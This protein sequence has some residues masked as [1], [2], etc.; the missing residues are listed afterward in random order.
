MPAEVVEPPVVVAPEPKVPAEPM[1]IGDRYGAALDKIQKTAKGEDVKPATEPEKKEKETASA[2]P[3]S[4]LEA[5]TRPADKK[6]DDATDETA[7]ALAN[8]DKQ[9]KPNWK[10]LRGIASQLHKD[11]QALDTELKKAKALPVADPKLVADL[12]QERD[13]LK[14]R[15]E[16]QNRDIKAINGRYSDEYRALEKEREGALNKVATRFKS[17]GGDAEA[18]LD[19]LALPLGKVR[20]QQIKE[21]FG[22][23]DSD[24]R[25]RVLTL[26]ENV[27]SVQDKITDFE[28]D[29]PSKWDEIQARRDAQ[30]REQQEA[31]LKTLSSNFEKIAQAIPTDIPTLREVA[32]DIP[33]AEEWN[34]DIKAAREAGWSVIN[35]SGNADLQDSVATA[36]KGKHYDSLMGRYLKL[37]ED[38]QEAK[39][40]LAKYDQSDPDFKG[41]GGPKTEVKKTPG[42]RYLDALAAANAG[43]AHEA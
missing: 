23:M 18:M 3:T 26:I 22:E 28:K 17:Y 40:Q 15:L 27:E 4:P 19:V 24:D 43:A 20:S 33:G 39:T 31:N 21:L 35:P 14:Q 37:H 16:T 1:K 2:K 13:D 34:R 36:I 6:A 8:L 12:T 30:G 38:F 5:V 11:K 25:A 7:T 42:E 10:E 9:E 29:L 41:G 32:E